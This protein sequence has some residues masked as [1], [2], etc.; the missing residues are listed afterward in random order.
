MAP[1]RSPTLTNLERDEVGRFRDDREWAKDIKYEDLDA[2][3]DRYT[4]F[5]RMYGPGFRSCL[6]D[7]QTKNIYT[8]DTMSSGH[9]AGDR[10]A[11]TRAHFREGYPHA[12]KHAF[13]Q[14]VKR[15][16]ATIRGAC[17][18]IFTFPSGGCTTHRHVYGRGRNE[19][20]VRLKN[21]E[22]LT[23]SGILYPWEVEGIE[24]Q[25]AEAEQPDQRAVE[26][27]KIQDEAEA[28]F[29]ANGTLVHEIFNLKRRAKIFEQPE[30]VPEPTPE[31]LKK[32]ERQ[33]IEE[34]LNAK[35]IGV[36]PR[37]ASQGGKQKKEE[38]AKSQ[39]QFKKEQKK[40]KRAGQQEDEDAA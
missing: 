29:E 20:F 6:F 17:G 23:N 13:C 21:N 12:P 28:E 25:H 40:L 32:A 19:I 36:D 18:N 10:T 8:G 37:K 2:E 11:K 5:D 33:K 22:P 39:K 30:A 34:K 26:I 38:E 7:T 4:A 27:Q 3:V 14:Q 35:T 9:H 1:R 31:E 24:R 16:S 15:W